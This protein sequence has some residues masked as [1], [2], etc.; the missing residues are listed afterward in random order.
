MSYLQ[1]WLKLSCLIERH[2]L[3]NSLQLERSDRFP[4]LSS[5]LSCMSF[6]L[7]CATPFVVTGAIMAFIYLVVKVLLILPLRCYQHDTPRR[8]L[9]YSIHTIH[10]RCLLTCQSEVSGSQEFQWFISNCSC[11][12]QL[13]DPA[14]TADLG[15]GV[16]GLFFLPLCF[17]FS[18]H[19]ALHSPSRFLFLTLSCLFPRW[20]LG[21][22]LCV[23]F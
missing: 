15:G 17:F 11:L 8:V 18:L 6:S 2:V 23:F 19:S 21:Q 1:L 14:F 10:S 22:L 9:C 4:I 7:L 3:S 13:V 20:K 12:K 16:P 5:C